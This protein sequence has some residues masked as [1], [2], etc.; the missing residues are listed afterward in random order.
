MHDPQGRSNGLLTRDANFFA[1]FRGKIRVDSYKFC[2][3]FERKAPQTRYWRGRQSE[4]NET[5][6]VGKT[7]EK[8]RS[9][10]IVREWKSQKTR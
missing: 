6:S 3:H 9:N 8:G 10:D 1:I 2:S 4:R 7:K 5:G